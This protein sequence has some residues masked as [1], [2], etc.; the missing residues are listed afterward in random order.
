MRRRTFGG[1]ASEFG[2]WRTKIDKIVGGMWGR[3]KYISY[4]S[5][6]LMTMMMSWHKN[7][8]PDIWLV[9][10]LSTFLGNY[11]RPSYLFYKY[12]NE[13]YMAFLQWLSILHLVHIYGLLIPSVA[14]VIL[15]SHNWKRKFKF[16]Y[17]LGFLAHNKN[18][19]LSLGFIFIL[20]YL[21][22]IYSRSIWN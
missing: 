5:T 18:S 22:L 11:F 6:R 4:C 7:V 19:S 13:V 8:F 21:F 3:P 2:E 1:W 12:I 10:I 15:V 14:P 20:L 16:E 9:L 17:C